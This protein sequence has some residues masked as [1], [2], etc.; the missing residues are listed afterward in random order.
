MMNCA[1]VVWFGDVL[2]EP[3]PDQLKKNCY[4][5]YVMWYEVEKNSKS[6]FLHTQKK[7]WGAVC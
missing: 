5:N 1:L 6:N 7:F 2:W 3:S 4:G